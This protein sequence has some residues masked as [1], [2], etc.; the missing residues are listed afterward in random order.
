MTYSLDVEFDPALTNVWV[1]RERLMK[2]KQYLA[3]RGIAAMGPNSTFIYTDSKGKRH[4]P[5]TSRRPGML[6][7]S[8]PSDADDS[9][10]AAL[11]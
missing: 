4:A 9:G 10:A 3:D 11:D 7:P 6:H 8:G 5:T 2:A 1:M